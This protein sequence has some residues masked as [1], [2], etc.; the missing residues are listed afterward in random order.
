MVEQ[1][2]LLRL[3]GNMFKD[4]VSSNKIRGIKQTMVNYNS[5]FSDY[6]NQFSAAVTPYVYLNYVVTNIKI[7]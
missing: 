1:Q 3:Y 6:L 4:A 5:E 7:V 2:Y